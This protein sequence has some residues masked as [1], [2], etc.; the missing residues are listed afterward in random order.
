MA[1]R[2]GTYRRGNWSI[3][4]AH[5]GVG[6]RGAHRSDRGARS[7]WRPLGASGPPISLPMPSSAVISILASRA[8]LRYAIALTCF[9]ALALY[10]SKTI[11]IESD[12]TAFLP[13]STTPEER[14]L[15]A[16]L[17]D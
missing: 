14:L 12:F 7:Q 4:A 8:V 2:H 11:R 1:S 16:Q 6:S 3:C 15:I 5:H 10:A 9:V 17:K 13:P